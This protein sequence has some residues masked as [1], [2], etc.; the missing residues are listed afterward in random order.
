VSKIFDALRKVQ[1][2]VSSIALPLIDGAGAPA[3]G[4]DQRRTTSG[5]Q[6][7]LYGPTV[8]KAEPKQLYVEE[9]RVEHLPQVVFQTD[10]TGIAADRFRLLRM[11]LGECWKAGKLRS[12]L[13]TS[14]LPGD[15][16][17]T[18]ALNL[19]TALAEEKIRS[20]LLIDADLH[21]GAITQQLNLQ[22]YVGFAESLHGQM[23]PLS[24]VRRIEPLGWH[25]LPSGQR[26]VGSPT[27]LLQPQELAALFQKLISQFDWIVVDSPPILPLSDAVAL[28]Q[29]V[30]GTLLVA[31]AGF[32][33]AKAVNNAISL[34]GRKHILGLVLNGLEELNQPYSSYYQYSR[35]ATPLGGSKAQR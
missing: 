18:T 9:T 1:G 17:S 16:K 2:E 27:E 31:K 34:L 22:Q 6:T 14:P 5:P 28:R 33:P 11:R 20:V 32:T 29:H 3:A 7:L 26:D 23:N 35:A 24:A 30:D 15:G 13:I 10:P 4:P 21:R 8:L 19:V 12:V 25:F